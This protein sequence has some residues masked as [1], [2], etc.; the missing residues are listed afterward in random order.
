M[1][2]KLITLTVLLTLIFTC[3]LT[4]AQETATTSIRFEWDANTEADLDGYRLY[5]TNF[6]NASL[7]SI[8]AGTES[9][10]IEFS[11]V[12]GREMCWYITAYD[13]AGNESGPSNTVCETFDISEPAP[14]VNFRATILQIIKDLISRWFKR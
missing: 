8:P 5:N 14:P 3:T 10:E 6:P 11:V 13:T 4:N 7:V 12:D 9:C 1:N 2:K